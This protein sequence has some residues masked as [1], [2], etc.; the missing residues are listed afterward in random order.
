MKGCEISRQVVKR[1]F[2]LFLLI[3][4]LL[5]RNPMGLPQVDENLSRSPISR[6]LPADPVR[7]FLR[8]CRQRELSAFICVHLQF[9]SSIAWGREEATVMGVGLSPHLC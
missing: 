8:P 3:F 4:H 5:G 1:L 9:H 7:T 2:L 6:P